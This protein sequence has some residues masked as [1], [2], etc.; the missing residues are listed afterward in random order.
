MRVAAILTLL[1]CALP[2]QS[3]SDVTVTS[4]LSLPSRPFLF[5]GQGWCV[6]DFDGDGDLDIVF[7][8]QP[9]QPI[10]YFRNDGGMSFS[11][12]TATAGLGV[13]ALS[14]QITPADV[15]N[16]GDL[17]IYVCNNFV[18]NQLFINDGTGAFTE[19]AAARGVD[20]A[21]QSW[22]ATFGDF[23]R[24]GWIDLYVAVRT[25]LAST[26]TPNR[27][28]R[29]LGNGYFADVTTASGAGEM[30][31][32][33]A[34]TWFD[35]NLDGWPDIFCAN[36]KGTS[37]PP[38]AVYRNDGNGSFTEVSAAINAQ[39]GVCGM[40]VDFIDAFND[41]DQ[42]VFCT[43]SGNDHV[44]IVW[45][46]ATQLYVEMQNQ[47]AVGQVTSIGW[48]CQFFDHDNDAWPDLHVVHDSGPNLLWRNPAAPIASVTPWVDVTA[49]TG[50]GTAWG[51]YSAV[52]ADFDLDGRVDILNALLHSNV[53]TPPGAMQLLRNIGTVGNWVR[54]RTRG[55]V[56]NRDGLGARVR[57]TTGT[58]TQEQQVRSGIGY[59]T[60][61]PMELHF[62]L[63]TSAQ[64]DRIE[65]IWPSG[66]TQSL[67]AVA[68]NQT[69]VIREP[70]ISLSA[71]PVIGTQLSI[72]LDVQGDAGL[73]YLMGL[74][75]SSTPGVTLASGRSVPLTIDA[76]AQLTMTPGNGILLQPSGV[77][78]ASGTASSAVAIPNA[79]FLVGWTVYSAGVT[80]DAGA[81]DGVKSIVP[82][83]VIV[84][85]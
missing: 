61:S 47:L 7:P 10:K 46:P 79:G 60:G 81:P 20:L 77:L 55:V 48:A 41:G 5:L 34:A 72:D 40:G 52:V 12:Q 43:D 66:R 18:P 2:A 9:T 26:Y 50:T 11:D 1:V 57:V 22:G 15:D 56:S 23:D 28:F 68:A 64:A 6:G 4:G 69:I 3:F 17:D 24:D 21:T 70:S 25:N 35:Y 73:S 42:D 37:Q 76:V 29:N 30:G 82:G 33:L 59:L 83:P 36:D 75:L 31:L 71:A 44:F 63:G 32:T 27:L 49:A 85:Q 58:V 51:Q 19:D 13:A 14:R 62:G 67:D 65:I 16:D 74:A 53:G 38:N 84:V 78:S 54:V 80:L 8:E 45:D 39:Q